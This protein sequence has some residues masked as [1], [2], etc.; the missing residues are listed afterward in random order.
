MDPLEIKR[1]WRDARA[2]SPEHN[3][4]VL[5]WGYE[6]H[7]EDGVLQPEGKMRLCQ[8]IVGPKVS[9]FIQVPSC[10]DKLFEL[11]NVTHWMLLPDPPV[12]KK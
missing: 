12:T 3:S 5:A 7:I 6:V 9:C 4:L 2:Y 10:S 11:H 8:Y 1:E